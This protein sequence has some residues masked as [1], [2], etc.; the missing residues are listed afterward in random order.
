MI[1]DSEIPILPTLDTAETA[2]QRIAAQVEESIFGFGPDARVAA[3]R[4]SIL[5][6]DA[7]PENVFSGLLATLNHSKRYS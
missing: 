5:K 6:D 4:R 1:L 2:S 7:P 3:L